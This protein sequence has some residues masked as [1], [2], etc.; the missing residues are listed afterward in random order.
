MDELN[1][2][3]GKI[4]EATKSRHT[5]R[6]SLAAVDFVKKRFK[7]IKDQKKHHGHGRSRSASD[8][9]LLTLPRNKEPMMMTMDSETL[10]AIPSTTNATAYD[11]KQSK[12]KRKARWKKLEK[13]KKNLAKERVTLLVDEDHRDAIQRTAEEKSEK[14]TNKRTK[15]KK[16]KQKQ[17][18]QQE[19][20]RD[21]Y[22]SPRRLTRTTARR[23]L[24]PEAKVKQEL[25]V[26]ERHMRINVES[27]LVRGEQFDVLQETL[28]AL[29]N[30]SIP[31]RRNSEKLT[32]TLEQKRCRLFLLVGLIL[33]LITL[34][35]LFVFY[36][37]FCGFTL[38]VADCI[39]PPSPDPS[40]S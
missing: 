29:E 31:F 39:A 22:P 5:R 8:V 21:D 14:K 40:L 37:S 36:I 10:R 11:D 9:S 38:D 25:E 18:R 15:K 34:L 19:A 13:S 16:E 23:A 4:T 12:Q 28:E 24:T 26:V 6:N 27:T 32:R 3:N 2:I 1:D 33:F 7:N 20:Y 30:E 17:E 35:L